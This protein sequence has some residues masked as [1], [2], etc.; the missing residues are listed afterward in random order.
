MSLRE[1]WARF[2][3][4]RAGH[5]FQAEYHRSHRQGN[6]PWVRVGWLALGTG[7]VA[8]GAIALPAPGPGWLIIGVGGALVAR[9]SL[10]VARFLD[11]A[12]VRGR[13]LWSALS[14]RWKASSRMAKAITV[15]GLL[16][17]FFAITAFGY[18]WI[19]RT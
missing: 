15:L 5:R 11:S 17:A 12:E 10:G 16:A 14:S 7:L 19:D 1:A 8:I 18:W 2:K 3:E 4:G 13:Q 9:Q 6:P